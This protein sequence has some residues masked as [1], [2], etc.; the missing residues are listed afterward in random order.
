MIEKLYRIHITP[1]RAGAVLLLV[2]IAVWS[3]ATGRLITGPG[4]DGEVQHL[5]SRALAGE[6]YREG[7]L[8]LWNPYESS[9]MPL[10]ALVQPGAFYPPNVILYGSLPP[11]L[12]FNLSLALHFL[13]LALF[14]CR[15]LELLGLS[16]RA[17]ILGTVCFTFCG[18]MTV[19]SSAVPIF[20]AAIWIPA[21]FY[22]VEKWIQSGRWR[23]PAYAGICVAMPLLAGWAQILVLMSVYLVIYQLFAWTCVSDHKKL[24]LGSVALFVIAAL[25]V[26]PQVVLTLH[27][28]QFTSLSSLDRQLFASASYPPQLLL[29]L[30]FPCFFGYA[31]PTLFKPGFWWG[32]PDGA[33]MTIYVGI[34]PLLLAAAALPQWRVSRCVRF[35][36]TLLILAALM[37]FGVYT[38]LG[39]LLYHLPAFQFFHDHWVNLVFL[40]F[41]ITVLAAHAVDSLDFP[42]LSRINARIWGAGIPLLLI[43]LT[44]LVLVESR[45][46]VRS[47]NPKISPLPD[48]WIVYFHQAVKLNNPGVMIWVGLIL[49]CAGFFWFWTRYPHSKTFSP[50]A[51]LLIVTDLGFFAFAATP[52]MASGRPSPDAQQLL[53]RMRREAGNEPYRAL[54]L[55]LSDPFLRVNTNTLEHIGNILGYEP[56]LPYPYSD[57]FGLN[58]GG[59]TDS[60]PQ[61]IANNHIL[62]L[63]NV[64]YII[65]AEYFTQEIRRLVTG[66]PDV[67]PAPTDD[68]VNLL[69]P[70][71]WTG[72]GKVQ[73]IGSINTFNSDGVDLSGISQENI[74]I[75]RNTI[76]ALTYL[77]RA[78]VGK[79]K[80]LAGIVVVGD[81]VQYCLMREFMLSD[82]YQPNTCLYITPSVDQD[83]AVK[84]LTQSEATVYVKDI[85]FYD[86]GS[87]PQRQGDYQVIERSGD[88][89]LLENRNVVPRAYFVT[90]V[91]PVDSYDSARSQLWQMAGIGGLRDNAL[92]EGLSMTGSDHLAAGSVRRLVQESGKVRIEVSCDGSDCFLVLADQYMPGWQALI[93]GEATKI[94]RTNAVVRGVMVPHG[95]HTIDFVYAP[96]GLGWGWSGAL[97]GLLVVGTLLMKDLRDGERIHSSSSAKDLRETQQAAHGSV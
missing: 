66:G 74:K 16:S 55:Q 46:L 85:K 59:L 89:T 56:F 38:P 34:L 24:A 68:S 71:R 21:A 33:I 42:R 48:H 20:N 58:T 26:L 44:T 18:F 28:K 91:Q 84:F 49:L 51:T 78:D 27:F 75:K 97:A 9:G 3:M 90:T 95:S 14:T 17:A 37:A 43:A 30:L 76:Y 82:D 10:A 77:A 60:W 67:T 32:P 19:H 7:H 29:L 47:I 31:N 11:R 52:W 57:L 40:S 83:V 6:I 39:S 62:S 96:P 61:L 25:L 65:S 73:T 36:S 41:A 2:V 80:P 69:V 94:Y 81:H 5:P 4:G 64:R 53:T 87:L 70:S 13:L 72:F 35:F 54:F 88:L 1:F 45:R 93:D 92:V 12:A 22:S 15:Y 63:M 86:V 23:Y 8:P 79:R 50:L